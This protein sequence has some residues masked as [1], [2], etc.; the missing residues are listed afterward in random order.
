MKQCKRLTNP[1]L[2]APRQQCLDLFNALCV[3]QI[4][5]HAPQVGVWTTR[6]Y[7]YLPNQHQVATIGNTGRY[8]DATGNTVW[9]GPRSLETFPPPTEEPPPEDPL[10]SAAYSGTEQGDTSQSSIIGQDDGDPPPGVETKTF[11][12]NAA[13]RLASV[14]REGELTMS[15]RYNGKGERVY[16]SGSNETV[17]TVFDESGRWIG[18]YDANGQAVQQAIWLGDLP[19]GLARNAGAKLDYV[20]ADALG[21]PRV[22]I[23]PGRDVAVWRWDL[24]G[25]AFGE[26]SPNEDPDGDNTAFVLDMRY[27]GQQYDSATGFNYNYFRDYD[28]TTGRY[29]QSDPIGLNGGISTYGF[30]GGNPMTRIDPFGL[31]DFNA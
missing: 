15:Y 11:A 16:R 21:T 13:N 30:V 12:Y 17:Y 6:T 20:E 10:E 4:G 1:T 9:M 23:D 7:G 3:R 22:V 14:S 26:D 31:K 29:S 25:E 19:V 24:T 2:D 27:P 28:P 18:D 8:Y 5:E